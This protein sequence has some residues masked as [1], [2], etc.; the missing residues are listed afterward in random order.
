MTINVRTTDG[1]T[2]R[3]PAAGSWHVDEA[4]DLHLRKQDSRGNV[5]AYARGLWVSVWSID[6]PEVNVLI[7]GEEIVKAIRRRQREQGKPP[8]V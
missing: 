4:G 1:V 2:N 3:H 5:A 8:T 6:E 7:D